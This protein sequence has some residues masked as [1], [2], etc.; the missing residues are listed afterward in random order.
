[1]NILIKNYIPRCYC[2]MSE[3]ILPTGESEGALAKISCGDLLHTMVSIACAKKQKLSLAWPD[4]ASLIQYFISRRGYAFH[5]IIDTR[6]ITS[7]PPLIDKAARL[8][9]GSRSPANRV[10][11]SRLFTQN[12]LESLVAGT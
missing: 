2:R 6:K 9:S 7:A 8:F 12:Y 4:E 5:F 1:M 10:K 11:A 3:K